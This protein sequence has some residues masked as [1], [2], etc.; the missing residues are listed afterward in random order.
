MRR[1]TL[2]YIFAGGGALIALAL[3]VIGL[4][5]ANQAS[6]ADDYV[7]EQLG[8]QRITFTSEEALGEDEKTWKE[9]SSCLIE[10]AG[11]PMTT[12][13]QAE[14][15]AN[16]YIGMHMRRAAANAGYGWDDETYA[17]LG[18]IRREI[19]GEI[20]VAE[21]AGDEELVAELQEKYDK[22]TSLR[23]TFQTGETLRGMLL[24]TYGFSI[25][26]DRISTVALISLALA[27][28]MGVLSI[29]GFVHAIVTPGDKVLGRPESS[30]SERQAA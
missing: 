15:Y 16:Y 23:S 14:C 10:H 4:V 19:S 30:D 8:A 12:G 22:A 25:F 29:A 26:G 9:G 20:S 24:T 13:A 18:G 27:V 3:L 7:A 2:D 17:T 11:Q 28:L 5:L 6:F 1:K 21:E